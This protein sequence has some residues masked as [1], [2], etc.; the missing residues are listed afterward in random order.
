MSHLPFNVENPSLRSLSSGLMA[1]D[2]DGINCD[3]AE[4]VGELIQKK[5]DGVTIEDATISRKDH[6]KTLDSLKTGVKIGNTEVKIVLSNYSTTKMGRD[7][8]ASTK[9]SV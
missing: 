4:S 5:L 2:D 8:K 3:D 9:F 7:R 6:A 1:S